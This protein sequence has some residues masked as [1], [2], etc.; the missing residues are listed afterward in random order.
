VPDH[1]EFVGRGQLGEGTDLLLWG[2]AGPAGEPVAEHHWAVIAEPGV[3][4]GAVAA[5]VQVYQRL[6]LCPDDRGQAG[7]LASPEQCLAVAVGAVAGVA[8]AC[9][10]QGRAGVPG[11]Q[12]AGD[13]AKVRSR[14]PPGWES[15]AAPW[16]RRKWLAWAW[17]ADVMSK[18]RSSLVILVTSIS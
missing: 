4:R 14:V 18:P 12:Q 8:Q 16:A 17:S 1:V 3:D 2:C 13:A 9:G 11:G 15:V 5:A 6:G 7:P 10:L